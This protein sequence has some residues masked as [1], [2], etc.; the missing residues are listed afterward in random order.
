MLRDETGALEKAQQCLGQVL[1]AE[2]VRPR[3]RG[4]LIAR[5][6]LL[7]LKGNLSEAFSRYEDVLARL[8]ERFRAAHVIGRLKAERGEPVVRPERERALRQRFDRAIAEL[9][10]GGVAI[11]CW[12]GLNYGIV[13]A[14]WG[15]FPGHPLDDIESGQ[16]VVHNGLLLDHPQKSVVRVPF[17]MQP[18]P[19]WFTDHKNNYELGRL[20]TQFEAAPSALKV[21]KV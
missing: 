19:A 2:G 7:A 3:D 16:G 15:A 13:N 6:D 8:G 4:A 17:M 12:S 14:T 20:M 18:T 9:R 11:N 5:A 1:D 10:Y 21:P